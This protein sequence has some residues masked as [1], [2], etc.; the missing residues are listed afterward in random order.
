MNF[1]VEMNHK[2]DTRLQ[3][4]CKVRTCIAQWK[5]GI[6]IKEI[7]KLIGQRYTKYAKGIYRA[8]GSTEQKW[9]IIIIII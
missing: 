2:T 5:K 6:H 4:T 7:G 3:K 9:Q 1:G 8:I